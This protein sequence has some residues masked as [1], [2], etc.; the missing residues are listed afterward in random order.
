MTELE[1]SGCGALFRSEIHTFCPECQSPLLAHYD[2]EAVRVR[3]DRDAIRRRPSGMWRWHELLPVMDPENHRT[4]G[5][6]DTPLLR[7]AAHRA[8]NWACRTCSSRTR[9]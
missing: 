3:L 7:S 5:E 1:C 4:L 8:A 9:A 2:L 6:G